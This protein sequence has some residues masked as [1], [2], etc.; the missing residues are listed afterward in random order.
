MS[1]NTIK[2]IGFCGKIP[3]KGDFVQSELDNEFLKHWNE[4][5][6]AVVAVSKE[7]LEGNWLNCYLTSPIWHFSL[8]A[9][10]CCES[11]MIG[12]VIPSVDQV[13]RHFPFTLAFE[14]SG[15]ALQG[16]YKNTWSESFEEIILRVL[17]DDFDLDEWSVNLSKEKVEVNHLKTNVK[18]YQSDDK[19]KKAWVI[20]GDIPPSLIDLLHQQYAHHFGRYSIWWTLGSEI[21]EPCF[22]VTEGL[23]QV[24]Q[25]VAMLNGQWQENSWNIAKILKE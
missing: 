25:F 1:E 10:I 23:P 17:D 7:Q 11:A 6:Q 21:V 19:L 3:T 5:L 14:H 16:W 22:I 4:W 13:S 24:S 8:S 9:G 12:T 2:S 20:Q 18:S 15:S